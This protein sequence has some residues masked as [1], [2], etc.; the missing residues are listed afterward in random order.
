MSRM[1]FLAEAPSVPKML[2]AGM[3]L[4]FGYPSTEAQSRNIIFFSCRDAIIRS[5]RRWKASNQASWE[6][7]NSVDKTLSYQVLVKFFQLFLV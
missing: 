2:N 1:S 5:S 7:L 6:V 3:N 4:E